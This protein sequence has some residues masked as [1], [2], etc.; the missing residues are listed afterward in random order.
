MKNSVEELKSIFQPAKER[1]S[2][3]EDTSIKINYFEE[4]KG[5]RMKKNEQS[6]RIL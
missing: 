5:K 1:I 2:K 4:Q 3:L 6:L